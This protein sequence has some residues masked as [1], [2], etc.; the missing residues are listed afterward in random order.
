MRGLRD[1]RRPPGLQGPPGPAGGGPPGASGGCGS[2]RGPGPP[3]VVGFAFFF[4]GRS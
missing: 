1:T 3:G 4:A 2:F